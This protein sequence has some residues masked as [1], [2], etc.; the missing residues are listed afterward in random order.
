MCNSTRRD[1][2]GGRGGGGNGGGGGG[3]G[4]FA[5]MVD[6]AILAAFGVGIVAMW[7][8]DQYTAAQQRRLE[9]MRRDAWAEWER[10]TIMDDAE[11]G[12]R[13]AAGTLAEL[14]GTLAGM[15]ASIE[16]AHAHDAQDA[17]D[18]GTDERTMVLQRWKRCVVVALAQHEGTYAHVA[19]PAVF[20][21]ELRRLFA[22][23]FIGRIAGS[24]TDEFRQL[25]LWRRPAQTPTRAEVVTPGD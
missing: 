14:A 22:H 11:D 9:R 13:R 25:L 3:Y 16:G 19:V 10:S 7:R 12:A 23:Q 18:D 8:R 6:L 15:A 1:D 20:A 2:N 5:L 24:Y 17:A 21:E 4:A